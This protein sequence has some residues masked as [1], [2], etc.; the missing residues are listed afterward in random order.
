MMF[1]QTLRRFLA[2]SGMVMGLCAG[3]L[4][5]ASAADLPEIRAFAAASTTESL[6]EVGALFAARGKGKLV[7]TYASSSTLAKQ[8]ENGAP[9]NLFISADEKWSDYLNDKKLLAPGSRVNLLGNRL[10]LIAPVDSK[11]ELGILPHFPLAAVL[12]D[13]RL[14]VGDPDHV[15]VGIY[16]KAALENLGVWKDVE[17]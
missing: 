2:T 6:N 8:I 11:I 4:A 15:P 12:K 13:G 17:G 14:S 3:L 16:T 1:H 9:A 10:A 7:A 5:P